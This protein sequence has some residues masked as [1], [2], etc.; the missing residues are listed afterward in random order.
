VNEPCKHQLCHH[1]GDGTCHFTDDGWITNST[2]AVKAELEK[3][4]KL[5]DNSL[6]RTLRSAVSEQELVAGLREMIPNLK[7]KHRKEAEVLLEN[8]RR[9]GLC[10]DAVETGDRE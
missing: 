10:G 8:M 2:P 7:G 1:V 3:L 6:A 4:V 5:P 9:L